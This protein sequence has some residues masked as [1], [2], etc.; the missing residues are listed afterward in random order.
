M[1][2]PDYLWAASSKRR[3]LY[4]YREGER[5]FVEIRWLRW[6]GFGKARIEL[7]REEINTMALV[8]K[9]RTSPAAL[10]RRLDSAQ[11]NASEM[12]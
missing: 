7:S 10:T 5:Y 6:F 12:G 2:E 1:S 4:V 8:L 11:V 3:F 9:V